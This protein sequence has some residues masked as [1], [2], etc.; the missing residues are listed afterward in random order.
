MGASLNGH[1]D[2]DLLLANEADPL[3]KNSEGLWLWTFL[4]FNNE[5]KSC[6]FAA[7]LESPPRIIS[8]KPSKTE[9]C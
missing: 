9:F 4:D 7:K 6:W 8:V 1:Q 5:M 3:F 2:I